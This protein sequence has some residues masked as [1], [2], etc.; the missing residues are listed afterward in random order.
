MRPLKPSP[1]TNQIYDRYLPFK[2]RLRFQWLVVLAVLTLL[3]SHAQAAL[4]F[5][6]GFNYPT[7]TE[8]GDTIVTSA[9]WEN[10]KSQFTVAAGSLV[11]D[12]LATSTGNRL[13]VSPTSASLD[14][15][16]TASDAW[17]PQA[18]GTLYVS[19]LLKLESVESID[20]T[21]DGTSIL[22][23]G[24]TA[25][26][27]HLLGINLL[28]QGGIK[29]GVLKYPSGSV[30]VSSA[31][32]SSGSGTNLPADGSSTCLI[33][34]KYEWVAGASNDIVTVWLNPS[35]LGTNEDPA[36]KVSTN[37]GSDGTETAGRLTL[38]RGPHLSIDE[39]RI[40]RT[41]AEVTPIRGHTAAMTPDV[42]HPKTQPTQAHP[43]HAA[44]TK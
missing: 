36:N 22:T 38:S 35:G 25:N 5:Y 26:N 18:D 34:A 37:T 8:L 9:R 7:R 14:S 40:G 44:Q 15:V 19:F 2:S 1:E 32:F 28:N 43:P 42:N 29:L 13:A 27:S 16:R 10:D 39:I 24:R 20:A 30:Q 3:C 23:I 33:V 4:L 41:W 17:A 11:R 6:E 31:F 21:G 12:G